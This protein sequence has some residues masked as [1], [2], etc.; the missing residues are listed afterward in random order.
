MQDQALNSR[1][2]RMWSIKEKIDKGEK[3]TSVEFE[4]WNLHLA[5]IQLYYQKN[6]YMWEN[7]IILNSLIWQL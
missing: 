3:L 6:Y 5:E 7:M 1:L 4:F 2:K